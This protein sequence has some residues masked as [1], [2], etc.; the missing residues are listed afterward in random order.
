VRPTFKPAP[1]EVFQGENWEEEGSSEESSQV[2]ISSGLG[3]PVEEEEEQKEVTEVV[4]V[5]AEPV[6]VQEPVVVKVD[7]E[8]ARKMK[9][10]T[11]FRSYFYVLRC[12]AWYCINARVKAQFVLDV[13]HTQIGISF[14]H[15][16]HRYVAAVVR[17]RRCLAKTR[18]E[19]GKYLVQ[20]S[21]RTWKTRGRT[22][23]MFARAATRALR[24]RQRTLQ[25]TVLSA[26]AD[27][28]HSRRI[29]R[30]ETLKFFRFMPEGPFTPVNPFYTAKRAM[31][32]RALHRNYIARIPP[33]VAEWRELV[34]IRQRDNARTEK[35]HGIRRIAAFREWTELYRDHFH[36]RILAEIR[37]R[38]LTIAL[39]NAKS[40]KDAAEKVEKTLMLQLLR[41]RHVLNS[42]LS[43][44]NRLSQNHHEAVMKRQTM[45][46]DIT[47]A[48]N[49]YFRRHE[50][51][52]L[53]ESGKQAA[54]IAGKTREVR[55]H[56][57]EGFLY[58]IARSV[59]SY[60]NQVVA[61][62]FCL[63]FRILSDPVVQRAVGYFYE[64]RYLKRLLVAAR[65][66][67]NVLRS[68][69]KCSTGYHKAC[70]WGWWRR[71]MANVTSRRSEGLMDVIRR[72]TEILQRYPYFQWTE[73]L[74]VKP[75]RSVR[76]IKD[77]F[78]DLPVASLQRKISRARNHHVNVMV[79][80]NERRTMR[81]FFRALASYVQVQRAL[82]AVMDLMQ[83]KQALR[84][85]RIVLDAF[86]L[87]RRQGVYQ[88]R[89]PE[90]IAKINADIAAWMR[91]FFR[92]RARQEQMLKKIPY[93]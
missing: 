34:R 39:R 75:P 65:L 74:S 2:R 68:A 8:A 1:L 78:K 40:Q 38:A 53:M 37:R 70:G 71:F 84:S 46:Q 87:Q 21:F 17:L 50:E 63:A 90:Q 81:D 19:W 72:R 56:L 22:A 76:E 79:M 18:T 64:K 51:N 86:V 67:H 82:R 88:L 83:A 33:I 48:T 7:R 29:A 59:L 6:V 26:Y 60:E 15:R 5:V 32:I 45:W 49:D 24:K 55:V 13:H 9:H 91:H 43:Q 93:S 61:H 52:Q 35:V 54:E 11:R 89:E 69:I 23:M 10:M 57:A 66:E 42:K 30:R 16:W 12:W 3:L 47:S 58:H 28:A 73:T 77:E 14:F 25:K 44:F 20:K 80:L 36:G 4:E 27:A 62:Q 31:T 85:Y 92:E 41:D